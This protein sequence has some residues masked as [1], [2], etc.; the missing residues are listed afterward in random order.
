MTE[1]LST[2]IYCINYYYQLLTIASQY[3]TN[4]TS[5]F[6]KKKT[7]KVEK[8]LLI[9]YIAN[10]KDT[11]TMTDSEYIYLLSR[12]VKDNDL[13][14]CYRIFKRHFFSDIKIYCIAQFNIAAVAKENDHQFRL[15]RKQL[16][17]RSERS[18]G[19]QQCQALHLTYEGPHVAMQSLW[20]DVC[21]SNYSVCT[22]ILVH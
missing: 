20:S 15:P 11:D 5:Q 21:L 9:L 2:L 4:W 3:L 14:L 22:L 6:E 10:W 18:S 7:F 8:I 17:D 13:Q 19:Q 16:E 12:Q 1:Y